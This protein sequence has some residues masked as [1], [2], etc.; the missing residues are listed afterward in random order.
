MRNRF[1][2]ILLLLGLAT[3]AKAQTFD[4][5]EDFES[6]EVGSVI[7]RQTLSG[8]ACQATVSADPQRASNHVAHIT[9]TS[10]TNRSVLSLRGMAFPDGKKMRDYKFLAFDLYYTADVGN[11]AAIYLA[12]NGTK[13]WQ[14]G[15]A[16][17]RAA[18]GRWITR[19]VPLDVL[20]K[21]VWS[22][23]STVHLGLVGGEGTE[24]YIDNVR[25]VSDLNLGYDVT[26]PE[27]TTRHWASLLDFNL[28]VAMGGGDN[29]FFNTEVMDNE[30][31]LWTQAYSG[32]FNITTAGNEMKVDALEPQQNS[33]NFS[34]ADRFVS[35]AAA[36]HMRVRGHTLCWHAQLPSW[37]GGG[38][39]GMDNNNGYT[40]DQLL[41]ILKNHITKVVSH[42]RGRVY[43]WD[44]VN[45]ALDPWNGTADRMRR[46]IWY[47]VIGP[48]FIDSAF[49]Y[50]RAA[51][52][53]ARLVINDYGAEYDGDTKANDL[54]NLAVRMKSRGIP[55]DGIGFQCHFSQGDVARNSSRI[56]SL[57]RKYRAKGLS[58]SF[59]EVDFGIKTED[60][61]KADAWAEQAKDYLSLLNIGLQC[62]N[63]HTMVIW[64][65]ADSYSWIPGQTKFQRGQPL[66]LDCYLQAKPAYESM[67]R[68]LRSKAQAVAIT[69]PQADSAETPVQ[70]ARR[71][72]YDLS[73][74]RVADDGT[75]LRPGLYIIDGH[76]TLVR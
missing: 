39:D 63:V 34:T 40:R 64:G 68:R 75:Q 59:T 19:T 22:R 20:G 38:Q 47:Q 60:F 50:A 72:T 16:G 45:E 26:D 11:T 44:V 7:T 12:I 52:P 41:R 10:S 6:R 62:D 14:D 48:D 2:L 3:A 27:T 28:G 56:L 32:L 30:A 31:N 69:T 35:F 70:P 55:I 9:T 57:V 5:I 67:L 13:V 36:H 54:Y 76:K 24:Y 53:D 37:M 49:V 43:E 21:A 51:D 73:G 18:Q 4:T 46:S 33:F 15:W 1:S 29:Q 8:S 42:Y 58:V 23:C 61:N 71:G 17:A 65:M 66:P 74:R 25:L